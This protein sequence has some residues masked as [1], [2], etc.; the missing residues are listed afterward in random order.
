[1]PDPRTHLMAAKRKEHIMNDT[2]D[3]KRLRGMTKMRKNWAFLLTSK[4]NPILPS[5]IRSQSIKLHLNRI[6][7]RMLTLRMLCTCRWGSI[8]PN[9]SHHILIKCPM[10][11]TCSRTLHSCHSPSHILPITITREI[12]SQNISKMVHFSI[13]CNHLHNSINI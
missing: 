11:S 10:R 13:S 12:Y 2:I 4:K 7:L 6:I 9:I 3:R 8:L 1:M 5:T